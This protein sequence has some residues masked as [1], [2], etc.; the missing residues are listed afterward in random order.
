MKN[1]IDKYKEEFIY[2][3]LNFLKNYQYLEI[4]IDEVFV[5]NKKENMALEKIINQHRKLTLYKDASYENLARFEENKVLKLANSFLIAVFPNF[6][7]EIL[8]LDKIT[9]FENDDNAIYFHVRKDY[10]DLEKITI[11]NNFNESSVSNLVHEKTHAISFNHLNTIE[12]FKTGLELFPIFLEKIYTYE[13]LEFN[14]S[15]L[16]IFNTIVRSNDIKKCAY[17]L[18]YTSY[19]SNLGEISFLDKQVANYFRIRGLD[20]ILADI[21]SNI[22]MRRYTEDRNLMI[23]NLNKV[24]VG[25]L[26]MSEFLDIYNINLL[27]KDNISTMKE[28]LN[29]CKRKIFLP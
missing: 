14:N 8:D 17:F 10:I 18:E 27:S 3:A 9:I 22:L 4:N 15:F 5:L 7:K 24:F 13:Y 21:Y 16:N 2:E 29:K 20:Y 23:E 1:E 6:K 26:N 19:L 25:K 12:L 11:S 28:E